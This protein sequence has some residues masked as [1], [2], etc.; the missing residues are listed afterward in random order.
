MA[1]GKI[2]S[3]LVPKDKNFFNLFAQASNNLVEISKTF[4]DLA[5]APIERRQELQ[6]KIADLEH[7]G[8]EL[9]HQIFT[10]LSSNFITPFD[11]EDISYL[12]SSL[13]DIVDYIHG[14]AKRIETYKVGEGTT[15]MKKLC[16]IIENSAKEIH[17]AVSN[18]KDMSN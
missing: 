8:D 7:V 12:A 13:D 2:F 11:R 5:N 4:S 9:T 18:L 17:V 10:E 15:G 6:K 16:E 14:S 1:L 3:F